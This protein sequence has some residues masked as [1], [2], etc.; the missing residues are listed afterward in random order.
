MTF[1]VSPC[2][3]KLIIYIYIFSCIEAALEKTNHWGLD[4][5][6][7]SGG[8]AYIYRALIDCTTTTLNKQRKAAKWPTEYWDS[9]P[10][11]SGTKIKN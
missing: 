9:L 6:Q 11:I 10:A 1:L 4:L 8:S 7:R 2:V 3:Y 5:N